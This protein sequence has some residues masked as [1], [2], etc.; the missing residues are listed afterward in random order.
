[1]NSFLHKVLCVCLGGVF[2]LLLGGSARAR[3]LHVGIGYAIPPYVITESDAGLE[4]DI[5]RQALLEAGYESLFIYLP[6][7]RLPV[8]FA[9]GN[10][11]CVAANSVYD[12][13]KD[14][15]R[16][17]FPSQKTIAY[18]NYAIT[19]RDDWLH[20]ASINDLAG[21]TVLGFNNA[22]LFLGPEFRAMARLNT[23]YRELDDQSLQVRMLFARRAQVVIA[24]K[25][26]FL[27]W[28]EYLKK[29]SPSMKRELSLPLAFHEIFPPSPR[30]VSFAWPEVRSA[31][32]SALDEL[33]KSGRLES[34]INQYIQP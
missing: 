8:E 10:L 3:E 20:I 29:V 12:L 32:D 27:W 25:F 21:K 17:A 22:R 16:S 15:G 30:R 13:G 33:R 23:N 34:I 18:R 1:M 9:K 26:I 14:S 4:V 24:D 28:R 19:L 7:L 5:I 11:D 2:A 6:N 31:F